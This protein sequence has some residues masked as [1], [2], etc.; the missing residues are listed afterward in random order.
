MSII[1]SQAVG[2]Y[3][4]LHTNQ[5]GKQFDRV[6]PNGVAV[7]AYNSQYPNGAN[8]QGFGI[9]GPNGNSLWVHRGETANGNTAVAAFSSVNGVG[10]STVAVN[11]SIQNMI[12]KFRG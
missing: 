9:S 3:G 11:P 4:N 2:A 8:A 1:T 7:A 12:D 5:Y 10:N 6:G